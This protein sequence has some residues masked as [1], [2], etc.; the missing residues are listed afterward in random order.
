MNTQVLYD[1]EWETDCVMKNKNMK[2][3]PISLKQANDF[4]EKYH[5]HHNPVV[6]H[7]FSIGALYGN[8]KI[9]WS[10]NLRQASKQAA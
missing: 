2:V 8:E 4:V 9:G 7:K 6:G 5:R 10:S 3:I 1:T